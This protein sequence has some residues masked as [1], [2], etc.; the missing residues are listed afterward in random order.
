M[1]LITRMMRQRAVYWEPTGV[2]R[3]GQPLWAAPIEI[4]CRWVDKEIQ[5]TFTSTAGAKTNA[6]SEL[7][8]S[9]ALVYVDRDLLLHGHL[10]LG[11][12]NSDVTADPR[13]NAGAW[14]ILGWKK[15]PDL[16]AREF[17]RTAILG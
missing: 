6:K 2:D 3:F 10:M 11:E 8:Q 17:L 16:K 12:L 14:E 9:K 7:F 13:E 1:S 5:F 15:T 4:S